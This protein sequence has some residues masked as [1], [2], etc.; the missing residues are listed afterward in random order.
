MQEQKQIIAELRQDF[1]RLQKRVEALTAGLQKASA[2]LELE[3]DRAML[4]AENLPAPREGR[5]APAERTGARST[6]TAIPSAHNP[7]ILVPLAGRAAA[8]RMLRRQLTGQRLSLSSDNW[9]IHLTLE[10]GPQ[11]LEDSIRIADQIGGADEELGIAKCNRRVDVATDYP[12]P[13]MDHFNDYLQ[14]M[15]VVQSFQGVIAV[16]PSEPSLL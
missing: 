7:R 1:A 10:E 6:W 9:E 5:V 11:V 2:Q 15:E 14:V 12:D 4:V 3:G 16:D 8:T 13:E